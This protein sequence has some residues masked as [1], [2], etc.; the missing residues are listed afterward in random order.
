[1]SAR[2]V[3][4]AAEFLES[5]S[6]RR[7]FLMRAAVVGSALATT[8]LQWILKPGTAYAAVCGP[9]SSCTS[10]WAVFCCS[11][12]KGVNKCPPGTFVGGWWKADF[13]PFCC[14]GSGLGPRYYIDCHGRCSACTRGCEDGFCSPDCVNCRCRCGTESCDNR[15]ACCNYFRYGQC[16]Q[17][18]GC[19][20]P[21]ACRVVTCTPPYQLYPSCTPTSATD[22]RTRDHTAPCVSGR[23]A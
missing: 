2:L 5:R 13:S 10:G 1:M 7:S 12:N 15:R 3:E 17:E 23:C 16:H 9:G 20:G 22:N 14:S 18:I 6:S 11:I 19:G 8:P 4:R 21:V